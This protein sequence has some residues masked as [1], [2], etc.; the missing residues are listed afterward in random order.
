M[1]KIEIEDMWRGSQA[2]CSYKC[3]FSTYCRGNEMWQIC[4]GRVHM[5]VLNSMSSARLS[6]TSLPVYSPS[7]HQSKTDESHQPQFLLVKTQLTPY[8]HGLCKVWL[9]IWR[10]YLLNISK[11]LIET[12]M[13]KTKIWLHFNIH[14]QYAR[15]GLIS[16]CH[17]IDLIICY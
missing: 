2:E 15:S 17:V 5:L 9:L 6:P 3:D 10:I 13:K 11:D 7:R 4:F 1:E 12:K 14:L 8:P 16:H